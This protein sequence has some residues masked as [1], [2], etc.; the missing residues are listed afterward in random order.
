MPLCKLDYASSH[1]HDC[2][3]SLVPQDPFG[4]DDWDPSVKFT[5]EIDREVWQ[6][7]G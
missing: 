5:A 3:T 2:C 7:L 1:L 6:S 4:E